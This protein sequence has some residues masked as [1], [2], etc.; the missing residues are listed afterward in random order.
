LAV[1]VSLRR[2][3]CAFP[4]LGGKSPCVAETGGMGCYHGKE[5]VDTFSHFKSIV[6]KKTWL[7]LPMRY[8]PF[9]SKLY[10]ALLHVF[11]R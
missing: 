3:F 11:L 1:K 9:K 7:D 2:H 10:E 5:G 4:E 6:D 8:Q